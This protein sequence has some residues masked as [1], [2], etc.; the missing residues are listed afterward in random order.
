MGANPTLILLIEDQKDHID[1]ISQSFQAHRNQYSLAFARNLTEAKAFVKTSEC[2]IA[3]A[4]LILP[5]GSALELLKESDGNMSFPMVIMA[6][7]TEESMAV[8][9]IK[10]GAFDFVIKTEGSLRGIP[11]IAERCIR[12]WAHIKEQ[13]KSEAALRDTEVKYSEIIENSNEGVVI[14][15]DDAI[16]FINKAG[17]QISGFE[18]E[19]LWDKPVMPLIDP[20]YRALFS[21][22]LGYFLAGNKVQ[23]KLEIKIIRKDGIL[24]DVELSGTLIQYRNKPAGL[25]ILRDITERKAVEKALVESEEQYRSFQHSTPIGLVRTNPEGKILYANP[26]MAKI[27]GYGSVADIMNVNTNSLYIDPQVR[28]KLLEKIKSDG[29]VVN[30]EAQMRKKDG[31]IFWI[32]TSLNASYN[33]SNDVVLLD[34]YLKDIT[35][36][37]EAE[38]ILRRKEELYSTLFQ[39]NPIQTIAVDQNCRIIAFNKAKEA[40]GDRL[41]KINDVMY[42]NYAGRHSIDMHGELMRCMTTGEMREFPEQK[43]NNKILSIKISPFENGA[44][45]TSQDITLQKKSEHELKKSEEKIRLITDNMLDLV[46]MCDNEGRLTFISPSHERILGHSHNENIGKPVFGNVHPDDLERV[47]EKSDMLKKLSLPDSFIYRQKHNDGHYLWLETYAHSIFNSNGEYIGSVFSSRDITS[48]KI[49]EEKIEHLNEL[50]YAIRNVDLLIAH[51]KNTGRLLQGICDC[52]IRSR[53]HTGAWIAATDSLNSYFAASDSGLRTKFSNFFKI[54]KNIH[55]L[56]CYDLIKNTSSPCVIGDN[57]FCKDC[58]FEEEDDTVGRVVIRLEY[59]DKIYGLMNVGVLREILNEEQEKSLLEEVAGEIAFGLYNLDLER[60]RKELQKQLYRSARLSAVGQLAAGIAHEFNNMLSIIL[61]HTQLSLEEDS[62]DEIKQSL[63]EIEKTTK[64][65]SNIVIKLA[66]FAKPKE[67]EFR[68]QDVEK[69]IDDVIQLQ[70]RQLQLASIKIERKYAA[71]LKVSFDRGQM[72]QVFLNLLIN[73]IHAIKPKGRGEILIATADVKGEM[74]I[75]FSDNGTGMDK[76]TKAKVF[77]PFFTTKGA[78]AK[79]GMGISGTGLGLS[80]AHSIIKQH[81][82]TITVKS[83]KNKGTTFI[84]KLPSGT[85]GHVAEERPVYNVT[86]ND[87]E[88]INKMRILLVDDEKEMTDIFKHVFQKAGFRNFKIENIGGKAVSIFKEFKPDIVFLDIIMP[89]MSGEKIFKEIRTI[90]RITPIVFMSGKV[91]SEKDL[92]IENGAFDY[93][94]K[95]FEINEIYNILSKIIKSAN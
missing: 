75:R 57:S 91:D 44:I 55:S 31:T 38:A 16:K 39:H 2:H 45:I 53:G 7:S 35:E 1:L 72:E 49:A 22:T 54:Q 74:E 13:K 68:V 88:K 50:L 19:E 37:K 21:D 51:E 36:R 82:G 56:N 42:K 32:S 93:I 29:A 33:D 94:Q 61:G 76:E 27:F 70:V 58:R 86:Q 28:K 47:L 5:D 30:Y 66:A 62:V 85:S 81:N 14:L 67:P 10:A 64:R 78:W 3:I 18:V 12:E 83:Q 8:E 52:L 9:A 46:S 69:I 71:K 80:I 90:N 26:M 6:D 65:G 34:G 43:Y 48:R 25:G 84:I 79:D 41:P 15:Q 87:I 40:S 4:N 77:D 24:R 95:P 89:D 92:Y 23:R 11:G 20:F 63:K 60:E 73:S 17:A 59:N